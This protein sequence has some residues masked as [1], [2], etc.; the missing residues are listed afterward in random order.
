L[1]EEKHLAPLERVKCCR[2]VKECDIQA[3]N[4]KQIKVLMNEEILIQHT[5]LL[6]SPPCVVRLI[7]GSPQNTKQQ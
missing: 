6:S 5:R 2:F 3:A 1:V 4:S 7:Y